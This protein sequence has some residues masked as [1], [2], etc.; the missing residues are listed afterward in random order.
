MKKLL[1]TIRTQEFNQVSVFSTPS[2][3]NQ[4]NDDAR[5]CR[6]CARNLHAQI[7]ICKQITFVATNIFKFSRLF[8]TAFAQW[9]TGLAMKAPI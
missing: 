6:N 9:F 2:A 1:A 8:G 5:M 3:E 7:N 4:L